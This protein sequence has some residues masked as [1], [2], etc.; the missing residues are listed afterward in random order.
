[1]ECMGQDAL[2]ILGPDLAFGVGGR[3]AQRPAP[4]ADGMRVLSALG[5]VDRSYVFYIKT[6]IAK[7]NK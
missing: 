3:Q 7:I 1:M 5:G 6:V 4:E 2:S